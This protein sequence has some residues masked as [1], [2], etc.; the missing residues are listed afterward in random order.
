MSIKY[1]K[2]KK[3]ASIDKMLLKGVANEMT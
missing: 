1:S 3:D 2:R